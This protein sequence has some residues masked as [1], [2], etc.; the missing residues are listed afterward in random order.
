MMVIIFRKKESSWHP[1]HNPGR[2]E[3]F[4]FG[5]ASTAPAEKL[6][7]ECQPEIGWRF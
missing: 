7:T 2:L 4:I 3:A 1:S 5:V 6:S